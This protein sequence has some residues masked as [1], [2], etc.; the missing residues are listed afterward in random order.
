ML[1]PISIEPKSFFREQCALPPLPEIAVKIQRLRN[2]PNVG[3]EDIAKLVRGDPALLAQVL[4]IVNSA[5]YGLP[6]EVTEAHFAVAFLGLDEIARM[7]LALSVIN[8]LRIAD[9]KELSRF[10]YHSFYTAVCSKYLARRFEPLLPPEELWSASMLHDIGKLVYLRFFP[11][12]HK[13]LRET[14]LRNECLFSEAEGELSLPPSSHLGALLADH[15]SLPR[16]VK[17]ACRIHTLA[18]LHGKSEWISSAPAARV[19]CLGNLFAVLTIDLLSGEKR[20]I[21][22]EAIRT[23]LAQSP[24]DFLLMSAEMYELRQEVD[25]FANGLVV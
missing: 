18:D 8:T 2:D 23:D 14:C 19:V 22:S 10:W 12:H 11:D 25:R 16:S 6:R 9:K 13:A 20:Q 21:V 5:Y 7:V 15:W 17:D 1:T 4:K 24:D 3:I